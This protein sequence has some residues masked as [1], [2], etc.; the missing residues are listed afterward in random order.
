MTEKELLAR[1]SDPT[2]SEDGL[3]Q[4]WREVGAFDFPLGK[5]V[6]LR[7][8]HAIAKNPSLPVSLVSACLG[9]L[10]SSLVENPAFPLLLIQNP[11]LI[12]TA[13]EETLLRLLRHADASATMLQLLTNHSVSSMRE[14]ARLHVGLLGEATDEQVWAELKT[15]K[16]GGKEKLELLHA[17]GL[18]PV[19]LATHHK[20]RAPQPRT[21][22]SYL[23]DELTVDAPEAL[24]AVVRWV[25]RNGNSGMIVVLSGAHLAPGELLNETALSPRWQ[26]RL[27]ATLNPSVEAKDLKRLQADANALVRAVAQNPFLRER[28]LHA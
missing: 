21:L 27:G 14:A 8:Q 20:L 23:A 2:L 9:Q 16:S 7:V 3:I 19:W 10:S 25:F 26:R 18:V 11:A 22:P 1:A 5:G 12:E 6:A 28:I 13:A 15:L 24:G 4:L 17:W